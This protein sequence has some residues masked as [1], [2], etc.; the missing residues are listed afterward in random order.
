M[1]ALAL[2]FSISVIVAGGFAA[3]GLAHRKP[4]HDVKE[5]NR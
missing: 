3:I 1:S 5:H 2:A 4:Y